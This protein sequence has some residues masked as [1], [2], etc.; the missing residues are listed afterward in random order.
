MV[1]ISIWSRGSDFTRVQLYSQNSSPRLNSP[2]VILMGGSDTSINPLAQ[3]E[4]LE[5]SNLFSGPLSVFSVSVL[6]EQP[7][8]ISCTV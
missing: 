1:D 5:P 7:S 8:L 2:A 4:I 3:A 6:K